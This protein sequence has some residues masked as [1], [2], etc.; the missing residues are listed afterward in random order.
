MWAIRS[1]SW[2]CHW[3]NYNY[4]CYINLCV[5]LLWQFNKSANLG[6]E[7]KTVN[8]L[9]RFAFIGEKNYSNHISMILLSYLADGNLSIFSILEV[10]YKVFDLRF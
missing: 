7:I 9:Y 6:Q 8:F 5:N 2:Y 4:E 1:I 10:L 3:W